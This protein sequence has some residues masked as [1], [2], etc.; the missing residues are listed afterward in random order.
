MFHALTLR[1]V[2]EVPL[3]PEDVKD[4]VSGALVQGRG[5]GVG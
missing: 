4:A 2:S 3:P 1:P 5:L